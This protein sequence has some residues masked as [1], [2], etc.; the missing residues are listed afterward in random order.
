MRFGYCF[1]W[2][3][4]FLDRRFGVVAAL[5]VASLALVF[6]TP[7][8]FFGETFF[9]RDLIAFYRPAKSIIARL[10]TAS[11]GLP[12]WNPYF[13]AGQP[14]AANPEHEIFHPLTALFLILPFEWAFRLQVI[15]PLLGAGPAM[16]ALLR[17]LRRSRWGALFGALS[18]GA[19]GY[20]LSTTNLLPILFAV[21]VLPLVVM[22]AVRVARAGQ[23]TDLVGLAV[24]FGLMG[25]A[26]EPSTLLM[27]PVV[28][29][30]ALLATRI[31]PGRAALLR[32]GI[33]LAIGGTLAG[34]ALLPG[35]HHASRTV[36]AEGV[37]SEEAGGWS[38]PPARALDL[39]V[40]YPLGHVDSRDKTRYWGAHLYPGRQTP[41]LH[42]LYPGLL[43]TVLACAAFRRRRTLWPWLAIAGGGFLF[44]LG[45]NFPLWGLLRQVPLLRGLRFPEKLSLLVVFSLVVASAHGFDQVLFGPA[46]A[47]PG[48]ARVFAWIA[49]LGAIATAV[50]ALL[51]RTWA[52]ASARALQ[53]ASADLLKLAL[54]AGAAFLLLWLWRTGARHRPALLICAL[55]A[56]DLAWTGR[57]LVPTTPI[58]RAAAAPTYLEPLLAAPETHLL[59]D[60]AA[61][62]RRFDHS[63]LLRDPPGPS[64]WGLHT[65]LEN[66]FDLTH[67]AWTHRAMEAFWRAVNKD[68]T[69]LGP[70]LVRRGVTAMVRFV[71]GARWQDGRVVSPRTGQF[72][73]ELVTNQQTRPFAFA[74]AQVEIADGA[75]GWVAGVLRLGRAVADSAIVEKADLPAFPGTPAPA[76]VRVRERR[77]MRLLLEVDARGPGPSFVAINQTWD[78]GWSASIDG[79]PAPLLRTEIALSGL[80][81]PAGRHLVALH[82]ENGWIDLGLCL[83]LAAA[84]A[85]LGLVI[86]ARVRRRP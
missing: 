83:S 8:L 24:T 14:F 80:V 60:Q 45:E 56:A 40:S 58:E 26:G 28:C 17:T 76:Q 34:A 73:V 44:A 72:P 49:G 4:G 74:A 11:E 31:P 41:Y 64:E 13:A 29:L 67:L 32:V 3:M 27:T 30:P 68:R 33:G 12:L 61:L 39:L 86:A 38:M 37:R 2:G 36:R 46:R 63:E 35:A 22:F 85:C 9:D 50:F 20:L 42:S 19:G 54:V 65:T 77:P 79:A 1:R 55:L 71:P 69:L 23:A 48:L 10:F 47:R 84:L 59:F 18:W 57:E 25:L 52:S 43:A 16:F 51:G 78:P 70:L 15:L 75:E 5:F 66:D 6:L 62:D 7:A 53:V 21:A 82:Y 81:V